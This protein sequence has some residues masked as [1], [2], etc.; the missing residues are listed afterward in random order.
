MANVGSLNWLVKMEKAARAKSKAKE[1]TNEFDEM[2]DK[3]RQADRAVEDL[4][5]STD[6]AGGK[7]SGMGRRLGLTTGMLGLFTS[8]L[9]AAGNALLRLMGISIGGGALGSLVTWLRGLTLT[10]AV[11]WLRGLA[12]TLGGMLLTALGKIAYA[13]GAVVG[14]LE[15]MVASGGA[16]AAA[17]W[18][19]AA[20]IGAVIGLFGVWILE[21]TGVLDWIGKLGEMLSSSL[22]DWATE[23]IITLISLLT[24]PLAALGG[25]IVGFIRGGFD[26]GMEMAWQIVKIQVR[27]I[28]NTFARL[29]NLLKSG[30]SGFVSWLKG[31]FAGVVNW[32]LGAW[33]KFTTYVGAQLA[34]AQRFVH[35]LKNAIMAGLRGALQAVKNPIKT[36][37]KFLGNAVNAAKNFFND[38]APKPLKDAFN[39]V[40]D[41]VQWLIDKI[42]EL[43][44]KLQ[45]AADAVG[46]AADAV[47]GSDIAGAAGRAA[48]DAGSWAAGGLGDL[49]SGEVNLPSLDT[50]GTVERSGVARVHAGE[51][52]GKPGELLKAAGLSMSGGDGGGGKTLII[53]EQTIEIGD[54]TLDI[55]ELD[56][57]A[58]QELAD[59][60]SQEQKTTFQQSTF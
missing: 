21:I 8:G 34:K 45:G 58:I 20:A 47:P 41:K 18:A 55:S 42:Q 49:A 6:N 43:I 16:L 31:L 59:A 53:E 46:N 3:A 4:N 48:G 51:V 9:F 1:V 36:V 17:G 54:Q 29:W 5:D 28:W 12:A 15:W 27:A 11:A 14:A 50:G 60:I 56:R 13:A 24:G 19:I 52:V 38:V 26:K 33:R 39:W 10:G 25:F 32:L 40:V 22:P 2:G 35:D 44:D 37:K 30:F 7:L 57:N 23:G